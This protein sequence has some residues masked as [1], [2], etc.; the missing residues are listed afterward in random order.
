MLTNSTE[1]LRITTAG[2]IGINCN[3]PASDLV[4]ASGGG[5]ANPSSSINAGATQFTAASSRTFKQNLFPVRVPDILEKI[6]NV[7]VYNYDFIQGPK[8]RMGLMAEDFHNIF[9]RGSDKFIDGNEVQ[10][11]LWLAVQQLAARTEEL[12]QDNEKLRQEI[13]ELKRQQ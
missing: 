2:D 12:K 3:A 11:A 5:C 6:S 7:G 13:E 4:I 1:R 8:N 10:M 9:A